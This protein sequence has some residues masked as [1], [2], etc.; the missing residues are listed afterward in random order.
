MP[1]SIAEARMCDYFQRGVISS[2]P[3]EQGVPSAPDIV[4]E[5]VMNAGANEPRGTVADIAPKDRQIL[6]VIH[7]ATDSRSK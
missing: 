1:F 4:L 3:F 2:V 7:P 6:R 5:F